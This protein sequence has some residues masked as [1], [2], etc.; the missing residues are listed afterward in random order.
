[1]KQLVPITKIIMTILVSIMAIA[2]QTPTE[3]L[4][5]FI[6]ECL[7]MVVN[8]MKQW[9]VVAMLIIFAAFLGL[10]Q[11]LG[12][13]SIESALVT[14]L[15]MLAMTTIFIMLIVTTKMQDLTVSLV[16][17]CKIPY[18]YAFM[19]T[20]ALRFVPDFIAESKAVQEAQACRGMAMEGNIIKR[21]KS[22]LTVIQPLMLKSLGRSETMALSLELRG[23]GGENHRFAT[24]VG[25]KGIDYAV[26]IIMLVITVVALYYR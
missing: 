24:K 14:A 12:S 13:G 10:V 15:R 17:Q 16:K 22:F 21:T 20:A 2:M 1:M 5:I 18:E 23:F 6:V 25:M 7:V 9:K 19:F 3:L 8:N 11:F 4:A 26:T